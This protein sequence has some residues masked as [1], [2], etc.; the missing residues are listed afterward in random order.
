MLLQQIKI[1]NLQKPEKHFNKTL[2]AKKKTK[3]NHDVPP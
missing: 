3:Q 2:Q 1:L